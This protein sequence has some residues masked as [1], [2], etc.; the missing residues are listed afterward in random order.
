[1]KKPI[2]TYISLIL[3]AAT[4]GV[5]TLALAP[6]P[7]PAPSPAATPIPI[8]TEK[9]QTPGD[10]MTAIAL[11]GATRW[12]TVHLPPRYQPGVPLPLV[13]NL[14]GRGGNLLRQEAL[15][16]MNAK[17]DQ[18]GFIAVHPQ[19]LGDPPTWWGPIPGATGQRDVDFFEEMLA[20]LQREISVDPARIYATGLSNGA[21]MVNRL[22]C[23]MA[24]TFAAIAPVSGG[25]TA[26][27]TCNVDHPVSVL[28]MH[29]TDDQ[30]IPFHGRGTDVPPVHEWVAAWVERDDC[31][32]TSSLSRPHPN[33]S[34][35]TWTNCTGGV[36]VTLY[37]LE[38]G[39]HTWPGAPLGMGLASNFP[40]LD[41]TDVIWDFFAS[42]PRASEP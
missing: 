8:P 29:G 26:F 22:G 3:L 31:D 13:V 41:A 20:Q 2:A 33:A 18:A 27:W 19:A 12:F 7:P 1:V 10:Y 15:T 37:S 39:G 42:H 5:C 32:P 21:T 36:E 28:V 4:T 9:Y 16:R 30:I 17:A 40:Y 11:H 34:R 24:A 14:H 25:H 35:E 23:D 38:G 6:H